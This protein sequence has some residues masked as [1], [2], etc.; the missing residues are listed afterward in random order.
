MS[1]SVTTTELSPAARA[2]LGRAD[3]PVGSAAQAA[4]PAVA[5]TASTAWCFCMGVL[6]RRGPRGA[7]RGSALRIAQHREAV[8]RLGAV[9]LARPQDGRREARLVRGVREVLGL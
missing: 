1:A 7:V 8:D 2:R 5:M 6:L 3:G 4:K 9:L